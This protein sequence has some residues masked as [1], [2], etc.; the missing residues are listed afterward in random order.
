[1]SKDDLKQWAVEWNPK[2]EGL[3]R[4]G[5]SLLTAAKALSVPYSRLYKAMKLWGTVEVSTRNNGRSRASKAWNEARTKLKD[6]M[7]ADIQSLY[8]DQKMG[9]YDI[10][11]VYGINH[12]TVWKFLSRHGHTFRSTSE[13]QKIIWADDERREQARIRSTQAYLTRRKHG[14]APELK[15]A[16]W[17]D[18]QGIPYV[19]QFRG[20][21]NKHPYDFYLPTINTIVEID[22]HYWH[23]KPKQKEKDHRHTKD[24]IDKGFRII[25]IC[26]KE[27]QEAN[28][29][30]S[31]WLKADRNY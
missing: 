20:V 2:A 8:H 16:Q 29:D 22:G 31:I 23:S 1:M 13:N 15:F 3:I 18:D 17:L 11:R 25:R 10:A 24:A 6:D 26:T 30:Y 21:G 28:G 9:V 27:L 4:D 19:E 12:V 14:T 7:L 5:H